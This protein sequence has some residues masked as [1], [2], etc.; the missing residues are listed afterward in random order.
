MSE[1]I[2]INKYMPAALLYFFFNGFLLPLGLLY[3][4]L[5]SP[6]FLLWQYKYP[7]FRHLR[8]F[9]LFTVPFFIIH[10]LQGVD[11]GYYL[12]SYILLFTVF[13]FCLAFYQFLKV[14]TSL[15]SIYK[16]LLIL[17]FIFTLI[18]IIALFIPALRNVLWS[19]TALSIG[20]EGVNRL[21][22]LTY[23]PSYYSTLMAPI[24][25]Y[26]YLKAIMKKL[27]NPVLML[28]MIS[29]PLLLSFSF[30]VILSMLIAIGILLISHFAFFFPRKKLA[31]YI[32]VGGFILLIAIVVLLVFFPENVFLRRLS[33]VFEGRDT[34]FKGRTFDSFYLGWE[35]AKMK[36]ILWGGGLGQTKVLG[37]ELWQTYYGN[38]AFSIE[39]IAIPNAVGDTLAVFG[40]S[41]LCIRF[42][43]EIILFFRTQV[44]SNY[45]RLLLFLFVFIYQFTGSYIFNIAE[46]VIWI[47]AFSNIF[48]GLNKKAQNENVL[49]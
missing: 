1:S 21:K 12:K 5:L 27:V 19:N 16:N 39:N 42:G 40:I 46:Y 25:L 33:N 7:S 11:A 48:P 29:L 20:I 43:L 9:F 30:G 6:V 37:L 10:Y 34:S 44:H 47:L 2:R 49:S 38:P 41:G 35:I 36:S 45:Y 18:S 28:I 8:L 22:L 13:V 24:A 3:T 31:L 32:F 23:E 15:G 26:Y 4:A 14:C 17:N